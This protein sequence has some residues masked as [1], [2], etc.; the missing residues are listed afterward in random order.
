MKRSLQISI[1]DVFSFCVKL[2]NASW[3]SKIAYETVNVCDEFKSA[4][5]ASYL[6]QGVSC[7]TQILDGVLW[8]PGLLVYC[9]S[10]RSAWG[11]QMHV[12]SMQH[13][14]CIQTK[15]SMCWLLAKSTVYCL[16]EFNGTDT[17]VL[18]IVMHQY[19]SPHVQCTRPLV[20]HM[21]TVMQM[22]HT[23][24]SYL[25]HIFDTPRMFDEGICEYAHDNI[26]INNWYF[27]IPSRA[28]YLCKLKRLN[29]GFNYTHL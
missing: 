28:I 17:S 12:I 5:C 18:F 2:W 8:F 4:L 23:T 16:L 19:S 7:W 27:E 11:T 10:S 21:H 15:T 6:I 25:K 1:S 14:L 22:L 13:E 29:I 20:M 26:S 9:R 24:E 3:H